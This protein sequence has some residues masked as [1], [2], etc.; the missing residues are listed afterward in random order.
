LVDIILRHGAQDRVLVAAEWERNRKAV[1]GYPG[2][3][4]ASRRD[5]TRF[6]LAIHLPI[7]RGLTLSCDALQIPESHRGIRLLT[8]RFVEE[9]H[10]RNLPIH[11]WTVDDPEDMRRFLRMGVDGIQTDR[12]DILAPILHE[13][14]GR[15]L[16]PILE[17]EKDG[18]ASRG[19]TEPGSGG[20]AEPGAQE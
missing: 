7:A 6:F 18:S 13:F 8:P 9:A 1:L 12:P 19:H 14:A 11:V 10:A 20:M 4:G 15:P 3:W 17:G 16:P 2:P 5:I